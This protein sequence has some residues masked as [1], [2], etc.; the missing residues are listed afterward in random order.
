MLTDGDSGVVKFFFKGVPW[1]LLILK[2]IDNPD[3]E[4][5]RIK[6]YI[7]GGLLSK[8]SDCG[9]LEFR[10]IADRKYTLASINE[11][12]PTLPWYV[13]RFTQAILHKRVMIAFG[14]SLLAST[15]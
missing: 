1:P 8:R 13:Y 10:Q 11:F 15:V 5:Q 4:V 14:R 7:I 3:S 12:V 6:F 9:W 2:C